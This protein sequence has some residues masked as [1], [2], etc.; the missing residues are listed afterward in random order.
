MKH[1]KERL[2]KSPGCIIRE[3]FFAPGMTKLEKIEE[4]FAASR[5]I[6]RRIHDRRVLPAAT[7]LLCLICAGVARGQSPNL[8]LKGTLDHSV[9]DGVNVFSGKLEQVMPLITV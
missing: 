2:S 7:V 8:T 4:L 1:P 9:T 3:P 6:V 5:R